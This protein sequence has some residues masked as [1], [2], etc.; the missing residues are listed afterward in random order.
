MERFKNYLPWILRGAALLLIL[1]LV[2]SWNQANNLKAAITKELEREKLEK[3]GLLAERD[4]TKKEMKDREG[5]LLMANADLEI[6]VDRLKNVAGK[7]KVIEVVKWQTKEVEVRVPVEVPGRDCPKAEPGKPAPK[8]LLV[9]GDKGRIDVAEIT[10]ETKADNHVIVGKAACYR[11]TP[12]ELKLFESVISAPVSVAV[13]PQ[14][15][16]KK[17]WGA[18]LYFGFSKDGWALG[19]AVAL[20]PFEVWKVQLEVTPGIGLS[21]NGTFQGGASGLVRW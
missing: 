2:Y 1:L 13:K 12:S 8:I 7:V 3:A 11:T 21:P 18:G 4:A 6:E 19:P 20:P 15:D 17:R 14:D 9:E 5:E 16:P 10:Y